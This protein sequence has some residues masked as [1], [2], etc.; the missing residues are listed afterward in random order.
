MLVVFVLL[1]VHPR[2]WS[3]IDSLVDAVPPTFWKLL[4]K[5]S[6]AADSGQFLTVF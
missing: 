4:Q 2:D 3:R 5:R 6:N 1:A